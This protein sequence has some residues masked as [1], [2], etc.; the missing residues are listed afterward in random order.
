MIKRF[1]ENLDATVKEMWIGVVIWGVLS[2]LV[3]VWFVEDKVNCALGVL[4]GCILAMAGVWHMWMVL[5]R[6]L[7]LGSGAQKYLTAR[8]W[9][10]YGVFV[11]IFG[12]LMISEWANP[13]TAFL[14][15]MG[16]KAAAFMQPT[17]H[18]IIMKRR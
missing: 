17:V 8:S 13:L 14:G 4:I 15:L 9:M 2:E 11:L 7:D 16:M 3:T 5:E 1:F 12:V 6:A 18:K 10:R